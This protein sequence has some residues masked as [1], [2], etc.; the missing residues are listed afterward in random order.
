VNPAI[1]T[2][3]GA[4]IGGA[5]TLIGVFVNSYM[6]DRREREKRQADYISR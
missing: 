3:F 4:V 1:F 2:L 6:S 5:L